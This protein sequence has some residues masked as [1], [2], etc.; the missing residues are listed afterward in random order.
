MGTGSINEVGSFT[1]YSIGENGEPELLGT[2]EGIESVEAI[3][4]AEPEEG[5]GD[6]FIFSLL[7]PDEVT[8]T[9]KMTFRTRIRLWFWRKKLDIQRWLTLRKIEKWHKKIRKLEEEQKG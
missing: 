7:E 6:E 3:G 8:F 2:L 4:K 5:S 9:A 1:V